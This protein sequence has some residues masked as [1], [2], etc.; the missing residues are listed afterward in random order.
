M[1]EERK[2]ASTEHVKG[3]SVLIVEDA[4]HVANALKTMLEL[5]GMRVVGPIATTDQARKLVSAQRPKL[6]LVDINLKQETSY[7]LIDEL[8]DQGVRV[9]VISGYATP[10]VSKPSV[11]A[12]L[13]KPFTETELIDSIDHII[14]GSYSCSPSSEQI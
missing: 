8:H 13:Q 11:A 14:S 4:W 10:S 2:G 7:S 5:A 6:A 1:A 9:I 12:F 3:L